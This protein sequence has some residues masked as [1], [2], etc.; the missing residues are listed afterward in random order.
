MVYFTL[1]TIYFSPQESIKQRQKARFEGGVTGILQY[2]ADLKAK[3]EADWPGCPPVYTEKKNSLVRNPGI[4]VVSVKKETQP[5]RLNKTDKRS[6]VKDRSKYLPEFGQVRKAYVTDDIKSADV[7][8]D[9][10]PEIGV[11]R[12]EFSPP[13]DRVVNIVN[14]NIRGKRVLAIIVLENKITRSF[15]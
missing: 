5:A 10:K 3:Q 7:L 15:L 9:I 8:D 14:G 6:P 12:H 2:H 4:P 1:Y 13:T 11:S